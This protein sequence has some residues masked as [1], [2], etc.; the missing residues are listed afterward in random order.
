M[1][2]T[3]AAVLLYDADCG[4]CTRAAAWLRR[5]GGDVAVEPLQSFDLASVGLTREAALERVHLV[6]ADGRLVT[7]HEAIGQAL[8]SSSRP[9][10]R[11][12]GRCVLARP[13]GPLARRTYDTVAAH[14]H[15]LPGGTAACAVDPTDRALGTAPRVEGLIVD[16][17]DPERLAA[18]W[19][20]LLDTGLESR[21]GPYVFLAEQPGRPAMGFQRVPAP[22]PG[23]PR[24][25][26]DLSA[27]DL[28]ATARRVLAL[29]GTS[30]QREYAEGGFLVM[31]DPE[32]NPFCL[33]PRSSW[34][35]D[36]QGVAHYEV[37]AL[38]D[39]S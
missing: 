5:L 18:F 32:G 13:L 12:L 11:L 14:R 8:R 35:L 22:T 1:G 20:A 7:G 9:W 27:H 4:F 34:D 38:P 29:G 21:V 2:A 3:P 39:S 19:A 30:L 15:R 17:L 25:H 24:L 36:D 28:E 33:L 6:T 31:A 16:C 10:A 37:P 26:L 23:K